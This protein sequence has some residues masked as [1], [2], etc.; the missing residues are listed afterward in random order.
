MGARLSGAPCIKEANG[1]T[2]A[3]GMREALK[4]PE[5]WLEWGRKEGDGE[6]DTRQDGG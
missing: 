2:G 3:A 4:R 1:K 5:S 6:E